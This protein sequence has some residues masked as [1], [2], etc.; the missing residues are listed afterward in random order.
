MFLGIFVPSSPYES[1]E[2]KRHDEKEIYSFAVLLV[3]ASEKAIDCTLKHSWR[4][5]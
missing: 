4:M 2:E 5:R 1:F 3:V